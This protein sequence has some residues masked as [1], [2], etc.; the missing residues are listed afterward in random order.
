ME[1]ISLGLRILIDSNIFL[2][3]IRKRFDLFEEIERQI[4]R[5][6]NYLVI[7]QVISELKKINLKG[8]VILS[9]EAELAMHLVQKCEKVNLNLII[10]ED[11]DQALIR[12][13]KEFSAAVATADVNLRKKLRR[14]NIPFMSLR[15]NNLYCEPEDPEL[16]FLK[17]G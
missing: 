3:S 9:K 13:S 4:L 10:G 12:A 16:W 14:R 7:P 5:K 8:K 17:K 11:T 2:L 6:I 15:G 1:P